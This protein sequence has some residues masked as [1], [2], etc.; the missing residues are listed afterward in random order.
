MRGAIHHLDLTVKDPAISAPFYDAVL[1][2]MGYARVDEDADS[3]DWAARP[4][5]AYISIGILRAKAESAGQKHNRYAPGLHHVAWHAQSREDVDGL[6]ALL[7]EI[8]AE[9]L[10]APAAYPEYGPDYYAV[11]FADPDGLKLEFV[12]EPYAA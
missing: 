7:Q 8:G 10:D 6:H 3:V 12:Y 1:G 11:F 4:A 5:G 9:I 2:F